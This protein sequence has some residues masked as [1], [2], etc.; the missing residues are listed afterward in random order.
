METI[1]PVTRRNA[2]GPLRR[3][4]WSSETA[5]PAPRG[6]FWIYAYPLGLL[7]LTGLGLVAGTNLSD[8][9]DLSYIVIVIMAAGAVLP[10]V[11]TLRRPI[12]AW[13]LAFVMLFVGSIDAPA[14]ES[15]PWNVVQILGFLLVLGRLAVLENSSLTLW[16]TASSLVPVFLY[17]PRANAWGAAVLLVAIAALGDIVSRRRRTKALLAEREELTEL[18]RA[19]RTVL[20]ERTRIARE[21]HDVVA[22]HMSMIAVRAETAPYRLADLPAPARDEL[23]TIAAAAREALTDMR[24]LL[25]VLRSEE[26]DAPLAPQPGFGQVDELISTARGAGL[27]VSAELN[28]PGLPETVSLAAYRIVQ[29]ALAN[30]SRHAPG[31]PVTIVARGLGDRFELTIRNRRTGP[32]PDGDGHGHGLSGMRERAELLGGALTAA[33]DGDDF[34]VHADLPLREA[35]PE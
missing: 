12:L 6:R 19:R 21:M 13:R 16:A 27:D 26:A 34:L 28:P 7:A 22:H 24:R 25:G 10:V 30:A 1:G 31:G 20:E 4:F 15:W 32:L 18:E 29:E 14:K 11:L 33:P 8:T 35:T 3:L 2:T 17:T 5:R 23:A 9:R